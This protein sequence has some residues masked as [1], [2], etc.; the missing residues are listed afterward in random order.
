[1]VH[2]SGKHNTERY[3]FL[4]CE[5]RQELSLTLIAWHTAIYIYK[6][7]SHCAVTHR[8]LLMC[9]TIIKLSFSFH[10]TA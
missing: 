2:Q 9:V 7:C 6:L 1:M 3:C 8:S 4:G 5:D 10:E